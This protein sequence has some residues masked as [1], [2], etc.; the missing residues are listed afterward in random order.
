LSNEGLDNVPIAEFPYT[1]ISIA[2]SDPFPTGQTIWR[3]LAIASIG[4]Q[5]TGKG[6]R[7][8]VCLDTG[9][10]C[11]LFPVAFAPS[12]GIDLAAL[13][14]NYTGGVGSTGNITY[15]T[16]LEISLGPQ[17]RFKSL[18]GFSPAMDRLGMGLLGQSGFFESFNVCF[19]QSDR[20]FT[21]EAA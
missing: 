8:L 4:T 21:V 20:R 6:L 14:R 11:C 16:E 1:P 18:A 19:Y 2:P 12:L 10:D 9:A 17:I 13:K 5:G 15:Y 7:C 3:P